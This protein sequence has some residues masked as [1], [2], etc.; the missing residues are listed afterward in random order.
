MIME[1]SQQDI[2]DRL[3]VSIA[4]VNRALRAHD[5]T[6]PVT[7]AKVLKA[8]A[9]L[10][11]RVGRRKGERPSSPSSIQFGVLLPHYLSLN[12]VPRHSRV[13]L[14]M[15]SGVTSEARRQ[16]VS[17]GVDYVPAEGAKALADDERLP[18][19]LRDGSWSGCILSGS[20]EKAVLERI[21]SLA[22]MVQLANYVPGVDVDCVDHDDMDSCETLVQLLW[23]LGHRRIAYIGESHIQPCN[24][25][26]AAGCAAAML[27]RC[28]S[29]ESFSAL[30]VDGKLPEAESF[31][32]AVALM[33]SGVTG[34]VCVHDGLGYRLLSYMKANGVRCPEDAS[35]CGFD[36]FEPP[37]EGIPKL[38]SIDAP[39]EKMG[40]MAVLRLLA[41]RRLEASEPL[42]LMMK[43][44]L[45]EG[46]SIAPFNPR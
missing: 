30:N 25:N 4:T 26:R 24:V 36:N 21:S 32:K 9:D 8:A 28:G 37:S 45:A 43:A 29:F 22:L 2:A 31:A 27:R 12:P 19:G 13:F 11:Y 6:N 16:G 41:K 17:I 35:V 5:G 42:R 7:R 40:S 18:V 39:F 34:W 23:G 44:A 14:R 15:L 33:R 3:G 46:A 1:V 10:G 38:V 20:F